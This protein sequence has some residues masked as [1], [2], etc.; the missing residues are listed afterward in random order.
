VRIYFRRKGQPKIRL[1]EMPGTPAFDAEY[2][3]A[4]SGELKSPSASRHIAAMP[5]TTSIFGSTRV[6]PIGF[7]LLVPFSR[8]LAIPAL[9][10]SWMIARWI[11]QIPEHLE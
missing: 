6:R 7:P 8:A 1:T 4:F 3:R 2:Q 9:I 10:R 5:Q 11:R